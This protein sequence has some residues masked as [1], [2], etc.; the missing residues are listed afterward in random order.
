MQIQNAVVRSFTQRIGCGFDWQ[1]ALPSLPFCRNLIPLLFVAL[2]EASDGSKSQAHFSG[3][4][5]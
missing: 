1:R 2:V 4:R 5:R 3:H